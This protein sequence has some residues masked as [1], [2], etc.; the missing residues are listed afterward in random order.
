MLTVKVKENG[1]KQKVTYTPLKKNGPPKT[2]TVEELE[3][4]VRKEN[5]WADMVEQSEQS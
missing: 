5:S 1:A 4:L 3:E 2:Y